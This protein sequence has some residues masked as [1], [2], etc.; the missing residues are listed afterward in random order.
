MSHSNNTCHFSPG[1]CKYVQVFKN[2]YKSKKLNKN[3]NNIH[4][5]TNLE[6]FTQRHS[7]KYVSKCPRT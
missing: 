2:F 4:K 5:N 1:K 7:L 6:N 3:E